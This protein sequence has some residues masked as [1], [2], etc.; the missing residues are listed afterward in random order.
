MWIDPTKTSFGFAAYDPTQACFGG[1]GALAVNNVSLLMNFRFDPGEY[2]SVNVNFCEYGGIENISS[3]LI[4]PA[5]YIDQIELAVS[6]LLPDSSQ[7]E[8]EVNVRIQ[9]ISGVSGI[10]GS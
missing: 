1:P 3:R 8:T 9:P 2:T 4:N 5:D 10:E 7:G 6:A